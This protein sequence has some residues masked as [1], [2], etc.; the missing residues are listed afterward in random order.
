MNTDFDTTSTLVLVNL[1]PNAIADLGNM[2]L[3]KVTFLGSFADNQDADVAIA[4]ADK[5][6][7]AE[8]YW[9]ES[10]GKNASENVNFM[11]G[12]VEH[13]GY[14]RIDLYAGTAN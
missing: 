12:D 7:G 9:F 4:A 1:G 8:N 5:H 3:P 6:A 11:V 14:Y 10:L 13:S 2:P